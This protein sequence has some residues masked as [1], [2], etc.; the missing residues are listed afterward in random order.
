MQ[1]YWL[2][3]SCD[4]YRTKFV[5]KKDQK[6]TQDEEEGLVSKEDQVPQ[7]DSHLKMYSL[8]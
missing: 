8:R 3:K 1:K 5:L 7:G 6:V 4:C 2:K